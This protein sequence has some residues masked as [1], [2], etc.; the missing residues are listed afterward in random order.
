MRT[1]KYRLWTASTPIIASIATLDEILVNLVSSYIVHGSVA[2]YVE[3]R[4]K[5]LALMEQQR[6]EMLVSKL[7][8]IE[9]QFFDKAQNKVV[10]GWFVPDNTRAGLSG[11]Q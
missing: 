8:A 4:T 11:G 1:I 6:G 9:W 10:Y 7:G 2:N 5:I 3:A